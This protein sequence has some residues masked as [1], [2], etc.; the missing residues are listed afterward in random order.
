MIYTLNF[1][2]N[3]NNKLHCNCYTTFRLHNPKRYIPGT[4]FDVYLNK[5]FMHRASVVEVRTLKL[6]QVNN[7]IAMVD[8]GYDTIRFINLVETMYKNIVTN[9]NKQKFDFVL[10]QQL[11]E[12]AITTQD[13]EK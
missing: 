1:S 10:L 7:F 3:W 4:I 8:T 9:F 6:E 13:D 12:S 2:V 11:S 5:H